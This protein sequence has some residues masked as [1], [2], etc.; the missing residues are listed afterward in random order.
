MIPASCADLD[1]ALVERTLAKHFGDI[2]KAAKEIGVSGPDLRRLTWARPDL[3][4]TALDEM[5]DSPDPR[6]R[7]RA[8]DE[9]MSSYAARNH[10]LSPPRR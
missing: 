2:C 10:P 6:R 7:E 5:L 3:L 1:L 9:I 8:P 4:Q